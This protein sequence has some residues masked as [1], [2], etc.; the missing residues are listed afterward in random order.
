MQ[1][2][3]PEQQHYQE[4]GYVF[5]AWCLH[6]EAIGNYAFMLMSNGGADSALIG[7]LLP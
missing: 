7:I 3:N 5:M 6:T 2:Y 1:R 4:L